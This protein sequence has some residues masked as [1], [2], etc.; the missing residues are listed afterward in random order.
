MLITVKNLQQ[1]TF[2]VEFDPSETVSNLKFDGAERIQHMHLDRT[3][4]FTEY[5][6]NR[7]WEKVK[8]YCVFYTRI[9]L[10]FAFGVIFCSVLCCAVLRFVCI[11]KTECEKCKLTLFFWYSI[12]H[13]SFCGHVFL[14]VR[15]DRFWSWNKRSKPSVEKI[16]PQRIRSSSMQVN[17]SQWI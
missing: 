13:F 1:Q 12:S 14:C 8:F 15:W 5:R 16:I 17:H 3:T 10:R 9:S 7:M 4:W 11:N 6:W 2:H